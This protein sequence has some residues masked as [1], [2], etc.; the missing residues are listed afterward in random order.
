MKKLVF[1]LAILS[2]LVGCGRQMVTE[3]LVEIDSLLAAE[4]NDS[5]YMLLSGIK[6]RYLV[7]DEDRAH[8]YLLMTRACILTG[9]TVP[10]D[11]CI[12]YAISFYE[13]EKD[14]GRLADAY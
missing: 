3:E 6:E 2:F 10:P 13:Q 4:K 5:A 14:Y 7:N 11:S 8:Y 9:N 12:D 1:G